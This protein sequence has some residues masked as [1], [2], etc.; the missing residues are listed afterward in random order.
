ML[1]RHS[2]T[3]SR[4]SSILENNIEMWPPAFLLGIPSMLQLQHKEQSLQMPFSFFLRCIKRPSQNIQN[5]LLSNGTNHLL[6]RR[7]S[8][9][10]HNVPFNHLVPIL[11]ETQ[12]FLIIFYPFLS[13]NFMI[14][15]V[16]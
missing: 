11:F 3:Q 10:Q 5:G 6:Q 2:A 4:S 13:L 16:L 8:F 9:L 14:M 1:R 12:P 15:K 7:L